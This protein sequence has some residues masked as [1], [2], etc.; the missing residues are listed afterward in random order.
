[1]LNQ[2]HDI[3]PGSAIA[4]VHREAEAAYAEVAEELGRLIDTAQRALAGEGPL[5]LRFN[6]SP[7]SRNGVPA[8]GAGPEAPPAEVTSS[9]DGS[10]YV[11]DNGTL[12]VVIDAAGRLSS[13]YDL[14]AEREAI[15]A[16]GYGNLLQ[17]HRDQPNRWDA[18]DVDEHYRNVTVDLTEVRAIELVDG[19]IH[20]QRRFGNSTVEQT[21]TLSGASGVAARRVDV[22]TVIDWHE[23]AKL[24]KAA[25]ALDVH[26]DQF[27]S[28]IQFG[29][30]YRPTHV[31]TSWEAARF[32]VCAHRWVHVGEPGYGIAVVND[33]TYGHDVN[34]TSRA[35]G[36]TTTTVRL[37]LLRAPHF[38]DPHTDQGTH[39]LNYAL[40]V[41]VGLD[42]AVE[43]GYDLNLPARS[44]RGAVAV[45]PLLSID[46][47]AIVIESVKLAEDR[48]G[49]I[50]VRLYESSGG[51]AAARVDV[52][53]GLA[54]VIETDL[55]E[56]PVTPDALVAQDVGGFSLRVR[57]FQ[58][59]TVR[60]RCG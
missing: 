21:I 7:Y 17:L 36:G 52:A 41:G 33:S 14:A 57:P 50:V 24:L 45:A 58:I 39:R 5:P 51:R 20:L 27:A 11:L 60:L 4:W 59:V 30:L 10:A 47:A 15:A 42:G 18:W 56:R 9:R 6:A 40:V 13:V 26:A 25:F 55:L 48:S 1:L 38:P 2:F 32:E 35:D 49:D 23:S 19:G 53:T 43:A 44:V 29:H 28:E 46:N 22:Q 31:N 37:S 16:Q 12:R 54:E 3:L 34:R 8:L